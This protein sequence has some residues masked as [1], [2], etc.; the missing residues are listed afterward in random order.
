MLMHPRASR[1]PLNSLA[2]TG[3]PPALLARLGS[4][5]TIS[6]PELAHSCAMSRA[7]EPGRYG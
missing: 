2:L 1:D 3:P 4:A 5:A 6:L 7:A